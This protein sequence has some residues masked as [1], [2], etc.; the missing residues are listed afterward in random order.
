[1]ISKTVNFHTLHISLNIIVTP[2]FSSAIDPA[3][4][5]RSKSDGKSVYGKKCY[6]Y[7]ELHPVEV[8]LLLSVPKLEPNTTP[9]YGT[10]NRVHVR[11]I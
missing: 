8:R 1:M 6:T 4:G 7:W 10:V 3:P 5:A 2:D 9:T 11:Q